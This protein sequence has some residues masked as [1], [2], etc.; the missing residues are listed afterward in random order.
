MNKIESETHVNEVCGMGKGEECCAYLAM[1]T[2]G[3]E[4]A[5]GTELAYHIELR[6]AMGTM[7]AKGDNCLGITEVQ[8]SAQIH[9]QN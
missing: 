6:L 8:K 4:C 1:G 3:L 9:D 5:K 2:V 7:N